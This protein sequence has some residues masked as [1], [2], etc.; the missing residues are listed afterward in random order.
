[1]TR[2]TIVSLAIL[3]VA[4]APRARADAPVDAG[5]LMDTGLAA[6]QAGDY[7]AA[8]AAFKSAYAIDERPAALFAIAQAERKGGDCA[9]A[10]PDYDRF[11][12]TAPSERQAA[13]ARDQRAVCAEQL[14]GGVIANPVDATAAHSPMPAALPA[15]APHP[16]APPPPPRPPGEPWYRDP[17]TDGVLGG[18]ALGVSLGLGFALASSS[19]ASDA[20]DATTYA[21]HASFADASARD[22]D[23]ALVSL[24]GAAVLGGVAVWRI[25]RHDAHETRARVSLVPGPGVGIGLAGGF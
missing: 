13:A 5:A 2:T 14:A 12:A 11:L 18:A 1:M 9:A 24:A 15:P 25:V 16:T 4:F 20:N 7:P 19:A 6:Y 17:L 10:I 8:I 23:V 21:Q 22:R 3:T